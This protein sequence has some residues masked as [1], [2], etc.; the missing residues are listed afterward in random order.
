MAADRRVDAAGGGFVLHIQR[1]RE[2]RFIQFHAHPMQ[3][4]EF[5][6]GFKKGF[7]AGT[8]Q[9]GCHG[10]G[11]VGG[12]LAVKHLR[13]RQ[14]LGGTGEIGHVGIYL[15]GEHRIGV[16]ALHLR[17]L[18]FGIPIG[19]LHQPR[20]DAPPMRGRKRSQPIDH[21]PG[22]FLIRLHRETESL[23]AVELLVA[24]HRA[25]NIQRNFQ[26]LGFFGV[27]CQADATIARLL[28][29]RHHFRQHFRH[30]PL[31]LCEFITRMQRR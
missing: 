1:V 3:P 15:A 26:S 17:A 4:L 28:G 22:A 21:R 2:Y 31:A 20:H 23:V 12:E 25:E 27:E 29:E 10:M 9:N 18:Y 8:L 11:I 16:E 6:P 19:T 14:H 30:H 13:L 7:T 24:I 5:K